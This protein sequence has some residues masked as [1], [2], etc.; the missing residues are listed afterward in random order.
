[1][2]FNVTAPFNAINLVAVP[3]FG[4]AVVAKALF[5]TMHEAES[6]SKYTTNSFFIC[7]FLSLLVY[8]W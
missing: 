8:C 6:I 3:R 5:C 4:C 1:V 2:V 7:Y